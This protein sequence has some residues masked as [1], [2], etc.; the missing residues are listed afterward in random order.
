MNRQRDEGPPRLHVQ[1]SEDEHVPEPLR[2]PHPAVQEVAL[3][4]RLGMPL[5][6]LVPCAV[7]ALGAR[8]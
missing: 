7:A 6:E 8:L 5:E 2:S 4:Q 1:E 3:H